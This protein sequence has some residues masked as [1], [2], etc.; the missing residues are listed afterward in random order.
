MPQQQLLNVDEKL[1]K[2]EKSAERNHQPLP[3]NVRSFTIV[4]VH[5]KTPNNQ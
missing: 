4:S 3:R 5:L 1:T 2:G